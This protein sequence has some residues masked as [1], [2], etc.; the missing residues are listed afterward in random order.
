MERFEIDRDVEERVSQILQ[1]LVKLPL[2]KILSYALK[3]EEDA[4]QLYKFLSQHIEEPHAKMKFEQFI[5]IESGHKKKIRKVFEDLF[6]GI[7][8]SEIPF[9]SWVEVSSRDVRKDI[10]TAEDYLSILK[11]AISSEK[12]AEKMYRFVAQALS[13]EYADVFTS[14][15]KDEKQHYDFLV[16]QYLFYKRAKA[17]EDMHEIINKLLGKE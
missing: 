6:P 5:K 9:P 7:E 12:L 15:A 17:E 2:E 3:G 13:K 1:K 14:L 8:P 11:V 10:K 16:N 4:I